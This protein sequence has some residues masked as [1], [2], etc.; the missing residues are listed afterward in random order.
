MEALA[1][2]VFGL[3]PT[4]VAGCIAASVDSSN[5]KQALR[6]EKQRQK[7]AKQKAIERREIVL[8]NRKAL[9]EEFGR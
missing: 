6:N 5:A 8:R 4:A 1:F 3:V 2:T 9:W 7:I